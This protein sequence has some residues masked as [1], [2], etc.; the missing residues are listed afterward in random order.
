[1]SEVTRAERS[2]QAWLGGV[3]AGLARHLGWPVLV[4]R[5][6]FAVAASF[7]LA[8]VVVY[9]ALWLVLPR[10]ATRRAP[11]LE[12]ATRAGMRSSDTTTRWADA[13]VSLALIL[14]WAGLTWLVERANWG[15]GPFLEPAVYASAGMALIWRQADR[16]VPR[17]TGKGWRRRLAAVRSRSALAVVAGLVLIGLAIWA[18]AMPDTV[19][20]TIGTAS[21]GPSGGIQTY[22]PTGRLLL[23]VGLAVVAVVVAI[24]P[25]IVR[26]R[27]AL[28]QA[29]A[30]HLVADARA[31]MA[32]HLHD[33]VL[34]TLALI[35]KNAADPRAV[36]ALA[37]RQERELRAY[38][39]G[40][41]P[42]GLR[43]PPRGLDEAGRAPDGADPGAD[44]RESSADGGDA[45]PQTPTAPSG[46]AAPED[47]LSAASLSQALTAAASD[48]E[49]DHGVAVEVVSVGDAAM[50]E[51][52]EAIVRAA[53]EA[54]VNAAV[55]SGAARVDVY[56][57]AD[58]DQLAVFVRDR[59]C[60][61]DLDAIDA[62][63][64]GVRR[65]IVERTQRAG[66]RAIIRTA[67]GQGT[68]VRLELP[69]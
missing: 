69:R 49:D 23:A 4:V 22:N 66:G 59:G 28:A 8:G 18:L 1:M 44:Q 56:A 17:D 68:E 38:L 61:F 63:R 32:A 67:P 41:A 45:V 58:D 21:L 64:A 62:D 12:A 19:W 31:D 34:Q 29:R 15:L 60:G 9:L 6:A 54:M 26:T 35:Q 13:G 30:D 51:G 46:T 33:S 2:A 7:R 25:W 27:R 3:C 5:V 42:G 36:A 55:H 14:V 37:R 40:D 50:D 24:L 48:V 53:R 20:G 57:E 39:Y 10:Q 43:G 16:V 47:P 52:V 11:G 65:S